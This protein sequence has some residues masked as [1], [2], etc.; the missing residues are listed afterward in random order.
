MVSRSL[1][2]C[3]QWKISCFVHQKSDKQSLLSSNSRSNI[4]LREKFPN[5]ELILVGIFPHSDW[6]RR[7]TPYLSVFSP[8]VGK[9]GP[10]LIPYLGTF[11]AVLHISTMENF[12]GDYL[13]HVTK[14]KIS[15]FTQH[16][17][18]KMVSLV[19]KHYQFLFTN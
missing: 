19:K 8:N 13:L 15:L 10:Q 16:A 1:K 7:D 6:I 2:P 4:A 18:I 14:W 11:H 17:L 12:Y 3:Y 9:Y 5:T